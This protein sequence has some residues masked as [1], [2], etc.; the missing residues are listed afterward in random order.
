VNECLRRSLK[1]SDNIVLNRNLGDRRG[2]VNQPCEL[3]GLSRS[4]PFRDSSSVQQLLHAR[5]GAKAPI[6]LKSVIFGFISFAFFGLD[7][8]KTARQGFRTS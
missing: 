2:T 4:N 8:S 1:I 5:A 3:N 6:S 7:V